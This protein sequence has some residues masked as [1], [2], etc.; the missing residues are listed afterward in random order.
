MNKHVS[1]RMNRRAFVIGTAAV[2]AGL[3]IGLDI[4]FGGPAVVRAADGSPEI[5][6]W[7]VVRPDDTVVIRIARSEMGQG[8][9]T[10]LAQLV[11]EELECD[12]SKVSTEYPTPGQSVA[13]KRVWGDFS[14]GGSRGIRSSQDYVRKGGATAR[15]ML[16]QAAAEAWKVP[17]SEC[18]A[19]NSVITHTP[20]GK[21]TTY[22]KVAE[23]AAKLTPPA[24]VKLKD[25]KDWKL[26][27][28]GVKRLDTAE[29]TTGTMVYG[30]DVKLPGMLNAAIK[31]CPV[32]GGKLKSYDEAKI[33]A[34]KG[35]KKVVKVGD[36]AVAVVADT[37]W[38]AKT[39]L[40]ALPIVWDEGDNAKVSSESIAKWLTEGLDNGQPAYVG[41]KNGDAKAAIAG[42]AKKIEAVYSYPYQN[43]ATMEP[44][45]AT[46]VY[47]ADKCE[48]WCGTQNGEAAFAA[49]LEASGLP[50][51]KCDVHKVM[52]GGGFGR[53][54]QTD[55]VRQAVLI[56][57]E[58]PGTPIKLL[59]SREEDMAHGR[60]HPI[61]Q[62]KMTGAFDA[63][64]NLV[65]LHYRLSGQ[66][67]L[68]SLR[69]EALQNGMDPA[70][71]QGVAQSGEAAF[72]YSVP[73][74]LVEHAMR[75]PHVP[76]GF[77]RGVNVNHNAIYMECFMDELAQAAGQDPLEFRRK[78]MGNHPKHLAVLNAVAEK[79]GWSTPAP[80]GIYRGIAQVMGYGSYVAGAAEISVTDGNKIKV[81][82]IVASTDP[83]Y[84]VNPAQV[85]R[86]IAGSFV[87]GLS[88]LFYGGCTVKDGK[89]E[90]TNFDTYNSMRINEM[91]K[92]ESV[93][94]PSGGFWGGVGEP[95][96][97]VAAPAVLNAYFAATGK[98]I[99]SVPLRDQNITFA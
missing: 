95:T 78:L 79:I 56:A 68:F 40:E 21:T 41:N 71:F 81:H 11:A 88:A 53:R 25:P 74:L 30:I 23:A 9:L 69:P 12:W 67:I 63:D 87:Y 8:S 27:G 22:G 36:T 93:M 49:T 75:N 64:N 94:V 84:V 29:K 13:R 47:T 45:N 46:A 3:A 98:R 62:C 15:V 34:M 33:T 43:H 77:W 66:S 42:A 2:G 35:V 5:G 51:E 59:W 7:V 97:G 39:A 58:M 89:I 80:Q 86:Q 70:A 6:A 1:P 52:P 99:R 44:M 14:T 73:N 18:T 31:D 32:F 82:R 76:P 20:S 4:P 65:A 85:E 55:Y 37:W 57:K 24:E 48:V 92:V 17:A 50:A 16:I 72:G 91:P 61:T 28:K 54:G 60:Y 19:A 38:H 83:G 90:Q 96:I 26:I 10:G